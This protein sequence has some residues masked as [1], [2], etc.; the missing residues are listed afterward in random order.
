MVF[1][2]TVDYHSLPTWSESMLICRAQLILQLL[3]ET[4]L[5]ILLTQYLIIY[6]FTDASPLEG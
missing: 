5:S 1:D 3:L 2:M 6:L 4:S